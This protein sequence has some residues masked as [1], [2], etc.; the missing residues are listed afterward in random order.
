MKI[1]FEPKKDATN[2]AKNAVSLT[3]CTELEWESALI[4]SA[5]RYDGEE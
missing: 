3:F 2:I 5:M 1:T 4:W